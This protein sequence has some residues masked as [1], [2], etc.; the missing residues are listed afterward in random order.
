MD[1]CEV[2]FPHLIFSSKPSSLH[3]AKFMPESKIFDIETMAQYD[4]AWLFIP[5][6]QVIGAFTQGEDTLPHYKCAVPICCF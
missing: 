1:Y 3:L 4:C 6:D 2:A 5:S